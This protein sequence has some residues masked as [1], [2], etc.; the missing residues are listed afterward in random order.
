MCAQALCG[1]GINRGIRRDA[2]T[3]YGV[4]PAVELR[5]PFEGDFGISPSSRLLT[6][7]IARKDATGQV[8]YRI[9]MF[10]VDSPTPTSK[11][12]GTFCF[13]GGKA[14]ISYDER[15]IITHHY[16]DES[17]WQELNSGLKGAKPFT[18]KD[19][20]RFQQYIA[21]SS[22]IWLTDMWTGKPMRLTFMGPGQFALYPHFR[23]DGWV[24]F[25]VR[26]YNNRKD[27]VAATDAALRFALKYPLN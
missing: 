6:S 20:P 13:K 25:L 26:D 1:S 14:S 10:D 24:Y 7:R 4:S 2:T 11:E 16:T 15:F 19:D 9:R 21:N 22:N 8:G 5:I 17:D 18:G 12:V 3:A 27:Y 23:A